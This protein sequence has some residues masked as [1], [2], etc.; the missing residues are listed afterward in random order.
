MGEPINITPN[1]AKLIE[2]LRY[3]T[4]T[5]ETA[6]ADIVDNSFDAGASN[7]DVNIDKAKEIVITDDG[8]GMDLDIM[9]EAIKLGSDTEKGQ[10]DL[11]RFGMGLVTAG[12]SMGRRIEVISKV[13]GG[14]PA[15]VVLDLDYIAE[16]KDWKAVCEALSDEE[17]EIFAHIEHGTRVKICKLDSVKTNIESAVA[18]HLRRVFRAFLFAG[19]TISVNGRPIAELDP[20]AREKDDTKIL[21]DEDIDMNGNKIHITVA[22]LDTSKSELGAKK[23]DA[24]S[25]KIS[26]STQ[27]FYIMRNSR[28]IAAAETLGL[29]ERHPSKNR[30]R[31]EICYNGNL[32]KEFGI[33]FTKNR[34]NV[35]QALAD[36]IMAK[37]GPL[38][39]MIGKQGERD[40]QVKKS[41]EINHDDAE[42]IIKRK[43][44]LLRTKTNWNEKHKKPVKQEKKP[45]DDP[46]DVDEEEKKKRKREHVKHIQPGNRAMPA[47]IREADLG[48]GGALFDCYFEG[49]KIVI[50]W[51]IRHPFHANL[52]AKNSDNKNIITPVDLLIYSLAQEQLSLDTDNKEDEGKA[53]ALSNA[54]Y[55]MSNNLRILMQ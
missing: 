40:A 19:Y 15:K 5:N 16:Q 17:S 11:G 36:K 53:A 43:K 23:E 29:F 52:I 41:E 22:H 18:R 34:I 6:V 9:K 21:L 28:E 54:I 7:I 32:D 30:F 1:A 33:N 35:S 12:I 4:Y 39:S 20:L 51:N 24:D 13:N 45:E 25:I 31:C 44:A 8:C 42:G 48:M 2:S 14:T 3:L 47:E 38:L 27:G 49:N 55:S 50:R 10:S 26:P 37:V 46:K